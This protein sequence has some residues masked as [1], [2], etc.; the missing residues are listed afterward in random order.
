M[1]NR[2]QAPPIK[3]LRYIS[4]P[5]VH[6][7]RLSNGI[8]AWVH[9]TTHGQL[10]ELQWIFPGGLQKAMHFA[11]TQLHARLLGE[12][13]QK[14]PAPQLKE[15]FEY[16][17]ASIEYTIYPYHSVLTLSILNKHLATVLH[18]L[19]ESILEPDFSEERLQLHK[20][21]LGQNLIQSLQRNS[22]VATQ[23]F[24]RIVLGHLPAHR[25]L[26]QAQEIEA[27]TID[28]LQ[29]YHT[30]VF[31]IANSQLIVASQKADAVCQIFEQLP[32]ADKN[33]T[34]S[35]ANTDNKQAA[36]ITPQK[37]SLKAPQPLQACLYVSRLLPSPHDPDY[38]LWK[39]SLYLLGGYFGS[40]LMQNLREDK[41]YTYGINAYLNAF[42]DLCTAHI[43]TEVGSQ[44]TQAAIK[45]IEQELMALCQSPPGRDELELVQLQIVN[46]LAESLSTP[47]QRLQF[48]TKLQLRGFD[49]SYLQRFLDAIWQA[50]PTDIQQSMQKY[51]QPEQWHWIVVCP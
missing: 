21:L 37:H 45:E 32:A 41:G 12:G 5:V 30:D 34:Q 47:S 44:Y 31:T 2:L 36:S 23:A 24:Y 4:A 9:P 51:F 42:T 29:D 28:K 10:T 20:Q 14:Q 50:K 22:Y 15:I 11:H 1:P 35:L 3:H 25:R 48:F 43:F 16:Y 13:S 49:M 19:F 40:R 8:T 17:G 26:L 46:D 33:L 39:L 6:A 27:T 38:F 18:L 7:N